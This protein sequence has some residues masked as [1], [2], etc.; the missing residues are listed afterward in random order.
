[1]T[2][3]AGIASVLVVKTDW[4]DTELILVP[5]GLVAADRPD[6]L[7]RELFAQDPDLKGFGRFSVRTE[8]GV[9]LG[10]AFKEHWYVFEHS[11]H[12]SWHIFEDRGI[13]EEE[14]IIDEMIRMRMQKEK[15]EGT[16]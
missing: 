8:A 10:E 15:K 9:W 12:G 6:I 14:T 16:E 13:A 2:T 5:K 3:D 4:T 1:M 7:M 11:G